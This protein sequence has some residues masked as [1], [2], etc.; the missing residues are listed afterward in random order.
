MKEDRAEGGR[1]RD[2]GRVYACMISGKGTCDVVRGNYLEERRKTGV[3]E[4]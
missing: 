2:G 1:K 3:V 4:A